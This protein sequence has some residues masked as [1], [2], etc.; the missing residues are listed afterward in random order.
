MKTRSLII[1]YSY[2]HNN[3]LKVARKIGEVLDTEVK[4]PKEIDP[5]SLQNFDLL[6]FGSGIYGADFH[7][8][9]HKLVDGIGKGKN[10]K[11]FLF[12]TVGAPAFAVES[13]EVRGQLKENH[14]PIRK[15]LEARGFEVLGEFTCPGENSNAFL[16]FFGGINKGRPNIDD[17][18]LAKDFAM[19]LKS[20]IETSRISK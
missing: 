7:Q 9:I 6:G 15:K 17:L 16:K 4:A 12:S 8:E 14:D 13:G 18:K 19:K 2:H 5:E 3:T 10:G 11:C 20:E 1:V